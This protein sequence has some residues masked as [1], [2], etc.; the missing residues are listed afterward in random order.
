MV[1]HHGPLHTG[2]RAPDVDQ[3]QRRKACGAE[4]FQLGQVQ[5]HALGKCGAPLNVIGEL[6]GIRGVEFPVCGDHGGRRKPVNGEARGAAFPGLRWKCV[7]HPR[8][9]ARRTYDFPDSHSDSISRR[10]F[11]LWITPSA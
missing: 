8:G 10:T 3:V 5:D 11:V 6:R 1:G 4:K 9:R 7:V 2:A